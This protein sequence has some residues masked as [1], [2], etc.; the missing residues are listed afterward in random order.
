MRARPLSVFGVLSGGDSLVGRVAYHYVEPAPVFSVEQQ[1]RV[2]PR[3]RRVG[4]EQ[5][6]VGEGRGFRVG[7]AGAQRVLEALSRLRVF[8]AKARLRR[9]F[10]RVRPSGEYGGA[11]RERSGYE[12]GG[13]L[14]SAGGGG[15]P[16]QIRNGGERV[17]AHYLRL[18]IG[19]RQPRGSALLGGDDGDEQ[20]QARYLNRHRVD[21]LREYPLGDDVAGQA[22]VGVVPSQ[23]LK[24]GPNG[25]HGH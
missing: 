2:Y 14:Q 10:V 13:V 5:G 20:S 6:M 3:G 15:T 23:F 25:V 1:S 19:Q 21:V 12:P 9:L 8:R 24:R 18:Q 17:R 16:A 7:H 11:L 4:F 22:P